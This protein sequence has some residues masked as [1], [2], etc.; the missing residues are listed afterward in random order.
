MAALQRI[1]GHVQDGEMIRHEEGIEF[2]RL[3]LLRESLE[4]SEIEIRVGIG[5]GIPPGPGVN[6]YRPHEGAEVEAT[7]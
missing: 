5:A 2:R 4:M 1:H 7:W 3:E 6:A